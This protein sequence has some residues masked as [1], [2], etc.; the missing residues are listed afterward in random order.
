MNDKICFEELLEV[1]K[2]MQEDEMRLLRIA[3]ALE[4]KIEQESILDNL[5][6]QDKEIK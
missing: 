3:K 2:H 1:I 5:A 6:S 4:N